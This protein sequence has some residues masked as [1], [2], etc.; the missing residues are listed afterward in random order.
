MGIPQTSLRIPTGYLLGSPIPADTAMSTRMGAALAAQQDLPTPEPSAVTVH[1]G[2][3]SRPGRGRCGAGGAGSSSARSA[4][5]IL[6]SSLASVCTN[7][8]GMGLGGSTR[9]GPRAC[10]VAIPVGALGLTSSRHCY[11]R[12][13]GLWRI[14]EV[15][16]V[17]WS[18]YSAYVGRS[19]QWS[20][21]R[22]VGL[23]GEQDPR[24]RPVVPDECLWRGLARGRLL[25]AHG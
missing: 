24:P 2:A 15:S 5:I 9:S 4:T 17:Q 19:Q 10:G 21:P 14:P 13:V 1:Y 18:G 11:R 7:T 16:D 20:G 3:W 6:A 12:L 23:G 25:R 22:A 8:G